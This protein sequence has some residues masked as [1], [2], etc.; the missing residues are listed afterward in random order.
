M[1]ILL[2]CGCGQRQRGADG[3]G[4][5]AELSEHGA[6]DGLEPATVGWRKLRWHGEGVELAQG[7][8]EASQREL[9][10]R[11]SGRERG[12][13]TPR[14]ECGQ[15]IVEHP[16]PVARVRH[17]VRGRQ[18]KCLARGQLVACDGG[19]HQALLVVRELGQRLRDGR[20][21]GAVADRGAGLRPEAPGEQQ[22]ALDPACLAAA[23]QRDGPGRQPIVVDQRC[24]EAGL[25]Q[26]GQRARRCIRGQDEPL[27]LHRRRH[28]LDHHRYMAMSGRLP[29]REP[30]V[31]VEHF[32]LAIAGL[33]HTQRQF[34]RRR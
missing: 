34:R 7:L 15:R 3:H 6:V 27:V 25:V 2:G 33:G 18:R 32:V 26:R 14:R 12:R 22:P 19:E 1:V 21:D 23:Q 4:G 11:S 5:A 8:L 31:P 16:T 17:T 20:P 29:A 13:S 9:Q 28:R 24:N 30:L 10:R